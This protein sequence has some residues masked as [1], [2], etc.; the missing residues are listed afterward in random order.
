MVLVAGVL[1]SNLVI[2]VGV[3]AGSKLD[4]MGGVASN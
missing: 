4:S 2:Y 1:L 3:V